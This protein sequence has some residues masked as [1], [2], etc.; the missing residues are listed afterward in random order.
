[1][2]KGSNADARASADRV[3]GI[4]GGGVESNSL[5]ARVVAFSAF[6]HYVV[7]SRHPLGPRSC[8]DETWVVSFRSFLVE[9]QS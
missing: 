9:S 7:Q 2:V 3:V 1:M 6:F 5:E 4:N 8:R